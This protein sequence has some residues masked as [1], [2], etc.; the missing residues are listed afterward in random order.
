M[1]H[2]PGPWKVADGL[3]I[4]DDSCLVIYSDNEPARRIAHVPDY[5]GE[6]ELNAR[7]IAA[8]PELLAALRHIAVWLM[9]P[10]T[11]KSTPEEMYL[12]AV[13]AIAKAEGRVG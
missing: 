9:S 8:A 11:A 13:N 4:E 7:L 6:G 1:P 3:T 5:D 2:T 10:G 12:V